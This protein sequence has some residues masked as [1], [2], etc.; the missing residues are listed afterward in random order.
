MIY[1]TFSLDSPLYR[2]YTACMMMMTQ[3]ELDGM[4][5][6]QIEQAALQARMGSGPDSWN[7][8]DQLKAEATRRIAAECARRHATVRSDTTCTDMDDRHAERPNHRIYD[9]LRDMDERHDALMT[10]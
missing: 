5:T 4:S 6:S 3:R 9:A 1:F 7:L 8:A 2:L 10:D